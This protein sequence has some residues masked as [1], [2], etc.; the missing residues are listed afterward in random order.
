MPDAEQLGEAEY[1][2]PLA[3]VGMQRHALNDLE[4]NWHLNQHNKLEG[5]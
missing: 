3:F 5:S 2:N 4:G 1:S